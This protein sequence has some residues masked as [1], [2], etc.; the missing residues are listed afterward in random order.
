MVIGIDDEVFASFAFYGA[1]LALKMVIMAPLTARHRVK[2][3]VSYNN[4]TSTKVKRI[5]EF[6]QVYANP[7]DASQFKAKKVITDDGDVERVRRAHL[8]DIENIYLYFFVASLYMFTNPDKFIAL[9]KVSAS[10]D[11][12]WHQGNMSWSE[13]PFATSHL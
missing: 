6:Y 7:E 12:T 8:N 2:K 4:F 13:I 10:E 9:K 11:S 1:I 5:N 3:G